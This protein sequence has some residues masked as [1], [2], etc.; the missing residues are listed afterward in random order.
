MTDRQRNIVANAVSMGGLFVTAGLEPANV[1]TTHWGGLVQMWNREVFLLPVR[2]KRYTHEL[3]EKNKCFVVNVPREN[4]NNVISACDHLSGKG[5]NKFEKL[6]LTPVKAK[7]IPS[8]SVAECGLVFECKVI[9]ATDMEK[10]KLDTIIARDMYINKEFHTL[11][12]GEVINCYVQKKK[13]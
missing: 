11:F 12:F 2:K 6:N 4:M 13:V 7:N 3:I 9:Y 8:V 5:I 1:M 10:S